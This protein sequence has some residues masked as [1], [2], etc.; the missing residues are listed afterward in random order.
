MRNLL[1]LLLLATALCAPAQKLSPQAER[2]LMGRRT[3]LPARVAAVLRDT[4]PQRASVRAFI[5]Y[6]DPAALDSVRAVGGTIG[7]LFAGDKATAT[8]PVD[9]LRRLA[10]VPSVNYIETAVQT[11]PL[12]DRG[13]TQAGVNVAH[14]NSRGEL[15]APFKGQG[16]VVGL[17]DNGFEYDHI[18][19]RDTDGQTRIRRVWDQKGTGRAPA[20]YGYGAEYCTPD[21]I[22]AARYDNTDEYHGTHTA[23]IAAGGITS[24]GY[25]GVAPEA[26]I[27]L[28]SSDFS[29]VSLIDAV[30]YIFAYAES[31]GKPCVVNLS[32]GVHL[33]PHDGTSSRDRFFDSVTGPGRIIVGACGNEG[34][35]AMHIAHTFAQDGE[36]LKT[37]LSYADTKSKNTHTEVW[38]SADAQVAMKVVAVDPLKGRIVAET[39][40]IRAGED[41]SGYEN[42]TLEATGVEASFYMCAVTDKQTGRTNL[43]VES[44]PDEIANNRR[45]GFVLTGAADDEVQMWDSMYNNFISG[46]RPGWTAGTNEGTVGEIGGTARSVVSVG[47][48]NSRDS[49]TAT[50]GAG[51]T[52]PGITLYDCASFSSLGPTADGRMKPEVSAPGMFVVS[53]I[54]QY[55]IANVGVYD[56][57]AGVAKDSAGRSYFYD[58]NMGTS[59]AAP[60]VTGTVALWLE[61]CPTLTPQDVIGILSR[62]AKRDSH[63]GTEPGNAFGYG[64]VQ[65]YAGLKEA[66]A[67]A[68]GTG[69]AATASDRGAKVWR[70]G[71]ETVQVAAAAGARI[72]VWDMGG[73]RVRH[74]QAAAGLTTVSL[75]GLPAGVYVVECEGAGKVKI[76]K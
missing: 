58:L 61:A 50:D 53:A 43:Y 73:R 26:D 59:M 64:R 33:G 66:I 51:L 2:L 70:E 40:E 42:F 20:A 69:I 52:M 68:S 75:N 25:H 44:Y 55:A 67:L 14:N 9:A 38:T 19:F 36:Q 17:V 48:Y 3:N 60:F 71:R 32:L 16:V 65:T 4:L 41:H 35:S 47:A 62:T 63:T 27:V 49:Y 72:S 56:Y 15:P 23:N 30:N 76:V 31:V 74:T 54:N 46:D 21:E 10:S 24:A 45:I 6:S 5:T 7:T 37:M 11:H 18:A 22:R 57:P 12:L 34:E 28:V 1:V 29:D 13:R 8:L 39:P